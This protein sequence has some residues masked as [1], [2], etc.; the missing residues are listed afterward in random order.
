MLLRIPATQL[1]LPVIEHLIGN[2]INVNATLVFSPSMYEQVFDSYKRG[3][4]S[5]IQQGKLVSD[6][7]CFTSVPIGRLDRVISPLI[8]DTETSLSVMQAKLLYQ[9]Y[10]NLCQ[11]VGEAFPLETR[12]R[13]LAEGVIPLR[14]VWDCTD[15]PP[16]SAWRYIQTLVARET[17]MMLEPSTLLRY[18]EVCLLPALFDR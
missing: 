1:L 17:V 8:T 14:L 2:R 5:L 16:E 6:V 10:R 4:E 12:W 7:V 15:I 13:S 3:L 9:H 18:R 11:S